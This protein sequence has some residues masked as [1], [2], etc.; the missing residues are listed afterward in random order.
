MHNQTTFSDMEYQNRKRV[1]KKEEFL[2]SMDEIIPWER[3]IELI[4]P[5]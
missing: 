4:K 5:Y 3:W 2:N 1:S